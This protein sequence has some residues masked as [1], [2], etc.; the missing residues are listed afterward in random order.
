MAA[1]LPPSSETALAA[2]GGKGVKIFIGIAMLL[3]ALALALAFKGKDLYHAYRAQRAAK[4]AQEA[5]KLIEE[6]H[7]EGASQLLVEGF[8]LTPDQPDLNRAIAEL[9]VRGQNDASSAIG[10][11]R[12][13]VGSAESQ[14][15]DH[16]RLA[17]VLLLSG[18]TAE[19]ERLY[20]ALPAAE[21]TNAKGLELLADI[22]RAAGATGE[23]DDLLR[24]AL[25]LNADAPDAQ[26]RL[27]ILDEAQA[28]ESA[29]AVAS[30]HIWQLARQPDEVAL[31]ALSHL[32]QSHL[33]TPAQSQELRALA[34]RHPKTTDKLRYQVL[35]AYLRLHPLEREALLKAEADRQSS[36]RLEDQFDFLRWLGTEGE[37]ARLLQIIPAETIIRDADVFLIY[38]EALSTAGRWQELLTLLQARRPP[39][40]QAIAH[41]FLA[42]CHAHLKPDRETTRRE[43]A[44]I[45]GSSGKSNAPLLL[46]VASLAESLQMNDLAVQGLTLAAQMRP[47]I[48]IQ[49]LEKIYQLQQSDR[50]VEGMFATLRELCELR[51]Q[52]ETYSNRLNYL[53]LVSGQELELAYEAVLGFQPSAS[54]AATST[55]LAAGVP[56]PLLRALAAWRLG[57]TEQMQQETAALPEPGNLPAGLRAVT[58]GLYSLSGREVEGYR[59]AEKV[60]PTLLLEGELWFLRR[61]LR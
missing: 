6:E 45:L 55:T 24:R 37:H 43:L 54:S 36:K 51:P 25:Q 27:A 29:K 38:A 60:P 3:I 22:K 52:N 35:H 16:R 46:R 2:Q 7:Y 50:T 13:V 59:L 39:V 20:Q 21:Q 56:P 11:L 10:F 19:A 42:Q 14:P 53:R 26:L 12:R 47:A 32:S 33:L 1:E 4:V 40:N 15:A 5:L 49:L 9:Y 30:E 61:S 34:E 17:E 23:A 44:G 58:A 48:R 28:F 31:R 18:E 57:E 8:R 41:F